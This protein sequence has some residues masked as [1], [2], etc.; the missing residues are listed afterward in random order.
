MLDTG[1]P[2]PDFFLPAVDDPNAEY[3]LSAAAEEG[4]TVLAFAPDIAADAR[5]LLTGLADL[6]WAA[7]ADR[8]SVFGLGHS[9]TALQ[10]LADGLP[11]PLLH[12]RGGYVTDLYELSVRASGEGPRR[13]L[14]LGDQQCTIRFAWQAST[15]AADPPLDELQSAIRSL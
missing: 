15:P 1:D 8:I 13:A 11:F 9:R 2:A 4:P 3:M 12:D 10:T 6:D 7:L 5:P 14:V